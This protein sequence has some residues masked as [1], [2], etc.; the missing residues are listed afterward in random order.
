MKK[1]YCLVL[2]ILCTISQNIAAQNDVSPSRAYGFRVYDDARRDLSLVS[3]YVDNPSDIT[4]EATHGLSSLRAAAFD[5][6]F[7]YIMDSD[8]GMVAAR[9]LAFDKDRNDV[10]TIITY[11]LTD[12]E[13]GMLFLDMAYDT[14]TDQLYGVAFCI[15]ESIIDG[16]DIDVPLNLYTIDRK[17]GLC[18]LVGT[19]NSLYVVAIAFSAD[20]T[21]YAMANDGS[22]W[23]LNKSNFK[24]EQRLCSTRIATTG[25]QSMAFDDQTGI[26]YWTAITES[27]HGFLGS[28]SISESKATYKEV[29]ATADN[30]EVTGLAIESNPPSKLAPAAVNALKATADKTGAKRAT[31]S[32]TNPTTLIGKD[33]ITEAFAVRIHRNGTL[34]AEL[35]DQ[36]PGAE[37][38]YTDEGAEGLIE[39]SVVAANAAGEG[40]ISYADTIFV[41]IDK[42]GHVRHLIATRPTSANDIFLQWEAPATGERGGWFDA[43][44]LRYDIVR[45]PDNMK[46]AT[47]LTADTFTDNTITQPNAYSYRVTALTDAGSGPATESNFIY[48]GPAIS[49]PYTCAF[50]TEN[51]IST[52]TVIDEDGDGYSWTPTAD[53]YDTFMKYFPADFLNPDT[54]ASD[55]LISAPIHLETGKHYR[56]QWSLRTQGPLFP[57]SIR[58]TLGLANASRD[59]YQTLQQLNHEAIDMQGMFVDMET[60]IQVN[61]SDD[62]VVGFQAL[63]PVSMHVTDIIIEEMSAVDLAAIDINGP[64]IPLLN[65]ETSYNVNVANKGYSTIEAY[66]VDIIDE[67]GHVLGTARV[68]EPIAPQ[69]CHTAAVSWTPTATGNQRIAA[70]VQVSGDNNDNNDQ[71]DFIDITVFDQGSWLDLKDG[72]LFSSDAPFN[73]MATHSAVQT[74]YP[75]DSLQLLPNPVQITGIKY[76]YS[77]NGNFFPGT[78]QAKVYMANTSLNAFPDD[79]PQF[80]PM[81]DFTLVYDGP[82]TPNTDMEELGI[83][84]TTPFVYTGQGICIYTQHET[85]S[86]GSSLWW[87]IHY[88]GTDENHHTL[89]YRGDTAYDGTQEVESSQEYPNVS[90]FFPA[91][92]LGIEEAKNGEWR[93][94]DNIDAVYDLQGR[95]VDEVS[96]RHGSLPLQLSKGIYIV[97]GKKVVVK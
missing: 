67:A 89:L 68:D 47:G 46:V 85:T 41:G 66:D 51:A 9:F 76:Y 81:S 69:Q 34:V 11:G 92:D 6:R 32:W 90:F 77:K 14:S 39:Y 71:T 44:Q 64:D 95:K 73:L 74:I 83:A 24:A 2:L 4:D 97:G 57:V 15:G 38:A 54:T 30:T 37:V 42:P 48:S 87:L 40:R 16:D 43:S 23:R 17:T 56:F 18:T 22:L 93:M 88:M 20:G 10:D 33:V 84:F 12:I 5:G 49:T 36:M 8:D 28:F 13:G 3:F 55:W 91:I 72:H 21:L 26:L 63:N 25:L 80:L 86:T 78:F 79:N 96:G 50:D 19:Q 59:S 65:V 53:R 60:I 52:W 31:L 58:S 35:A 7:Y 70:R 61:A 94:K 45:L 1:Y 29:G 75:K 62:Y 82:L 27:G